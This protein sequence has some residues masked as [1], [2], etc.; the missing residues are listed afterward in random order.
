MIFHADR[1]CVNCG[2]R[3]EIKA[4]PTWSGSIIKWF[5]SELPFTKMKDDDTIAF[6]QAASVFAV[7][8]SDVMILRGP[9]PAT[10]KERPTSF[11]ELAAPRTALTRIDR[12]FHCIRDDP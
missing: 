9:L 3:V 1:Q 6:P 10:H 7:A 4:S 12:A 2:H 8:K 5:H 11:F